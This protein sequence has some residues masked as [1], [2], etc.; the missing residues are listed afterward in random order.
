MARSVVATATDANANPPVLHRTLRA[1]EPRLPA[2]LTISPR[3]PDEPRVVKSPRLLRGSAH[4]ASETLG[5]PLSS[6]TTAHLASSH[7][8]QE[9]SIHLGPRAPSGGLFSPRR[10]GPSRVRSLVS[11]PTRSSL[12]FSLVYSFISA[13]TPPRPPP[14][15][16]R[17]AS[18]ACASL[19]WRPRR[20]AAPPLDTT[21]D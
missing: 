7:T 13:V 21:R 20:L 4:S 14:L 3:V 16:N 15:P 2:P 17:T 6:S 8:D 18:R 19:R 1:T 12:V 10:L 9:C 11:P 5:T